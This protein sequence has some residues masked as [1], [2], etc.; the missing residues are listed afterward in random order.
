MY[1]NRLAPKRQHNA[2]RIGIPRKDVF[3]GTLLAITAVHDTHTNRNYH[4]IRPLMHIGLKPM[5]LHL[6]HRIVTP[7]IRRQFDVVLVDPDSDP[8]KLFCKHTIPLVLRQSGAKCTSIRTTIA[9]IEKCTSEGC[10]LIMLSTPMRHFIMP[11][12]AASE[13][14]AG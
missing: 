12:F 1:G 3:G 9:N 6:I 7:S 11:S 5:R 2:I 14:Y 10:C 4:R 13:E 8:K